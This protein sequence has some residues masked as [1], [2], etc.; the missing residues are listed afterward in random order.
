MC[1]KRRVSTAGWEREV[2]SAQVPVLVEFWSRDS[3]PCRFEDAVLELFARDKRGLKVLRVD[4]DAEPALVDRYDVGAL[5]S[6]LLFLD[7]ILVHRVVGYHDRGDLERQLAD[8]LDR[9]GEV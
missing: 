5:P 8:F 4:V 7:G 3:A 2:I 1:Q 9:S 6:M